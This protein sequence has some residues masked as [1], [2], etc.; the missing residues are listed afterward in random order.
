MNLI[1]FFLLVQVIHFLGTWHLYQKAGRKAWEAAIPIYNAIVL[2]KIIK[3]PWWYILFLFIPVVNV[4]MAIILWV[5]TIRSFGKTSRKDALLV[6]FTLGFYIYYLNY[7]LKPDY[8]AERDLNP[9]SK[10][11]ELISA[12]FFAVIIATIIHTY[13]MQPFTIPTSSLEK[14]LLVG[15][16]LLVSKLHYGA[17][18]PSTAVSVPMVHDSIPLIKKKSY[19]SSFQYPSFRLPGLQKVKHN[20]IVCFNWPAD[21]VYQFFD[22]SG[23]HIDKPLDK[24]SNYVK[25]CIGLPGDTLRIFDGDVFINA[26]KLKLHD[27]QKLQYMYS[28]VANKSFDVT[29]LRDVIG[30]KDKEIMGSMD[31]NFYNLYLNLTDERA[32]LLKANKNVVKVEKYLSKEPDSKIFPHNQPWSIDNL[33]PIWIPKAGETVTINSGNIN[34]YKRIIEIYEN[35][36]LEIVGNQIKINDEVADKYT[37]K[38]DYYWMM[39]DNR[40]QSEDSRMWGF[41]PYDHVIGKP[42]LIWMSLEGMMDGIKNWKIRPERLFTTVGGDGEPVSHWPYFV[43]LLVLYFGGEYLYSKYKKKKEIETKD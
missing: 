22:R 21:T 6:V 27:R 18:T 23:R 19:L 33:G 34:L 17:R 4:L 42:V 35:N 25:R 40:H 26:K 20:D 29:F 3:R 41:V 39:G 31:E 8:N 14:S 7:V 10:L 1:L 32:A 30:L 2:T 37:F 13:V 11:G 28:V 9:K 5:E 38:Q 43:L 36:K 15:D 24:R 16:F 12:I